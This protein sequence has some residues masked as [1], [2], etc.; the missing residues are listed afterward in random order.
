[1]ISKVIEIRSG[2]KPPTTSGIETRI[3]EFLSHEKV[4]EVISV[5]METV[6]SEGC[7]IVRVLIIYKEY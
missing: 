1:M 4:G 3:N 6:M 5:S 7:Q 2:N